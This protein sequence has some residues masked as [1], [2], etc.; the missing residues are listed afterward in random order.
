[1]FL[2][3]SKKL[4]KRG[5]HFKREHISI[6]DATDK[7]IFFAILLNIHHSINDECAVC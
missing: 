6:D 1:M 2:C 7:N 4:D 3:V 5:Y